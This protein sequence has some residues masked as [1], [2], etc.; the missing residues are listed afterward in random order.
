MLAVKM[1]GEGAMANNKWVIAA[2][3]LA[4]LVICV[5]MLVNYARRAEPVSDER[6][7][8]ILDS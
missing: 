2:F 7:D 4:A 8:W 5:L 1:Q 6:I 3:I